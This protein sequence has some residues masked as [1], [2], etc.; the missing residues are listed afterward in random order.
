LFKGFSIVSGVF[1]ALSV[2]EWGVVGVDGLFQGSLFTSWLCYVEVKSAPLHGCYYMRRIFQMGAIEIIFQFILVGSVVLEASILAGGLATWLRPLGLTRPEIL[3][4]LADVPLID[5][6]LR[7][8]RDGGVDTVVLA[9]NNL[10][11][12]IMGYLGRE[13]LAIIEST[14]LR[15]SLRGPLTSLIAT[16]SSISLFLNAPDTGTA[17]T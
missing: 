13:S 3:F 15:G 6:T 14:V 17:I 8:L 4:P 2:V 10:A 7:G 12:V 11:D 16:K 1:V 9:V 5:Y